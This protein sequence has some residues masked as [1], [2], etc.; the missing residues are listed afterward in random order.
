MYLSLMIFGL[1]VGACCFSIRALFLLLVSYDKC[2]TDQQRHD[3]VDKASV[4][5]VPSVVLPLLAIL[6]WLIRAYA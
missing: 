4:V 1:T 6:L 2:K 3:V 5:L